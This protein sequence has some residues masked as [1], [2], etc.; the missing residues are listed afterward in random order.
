MEYGPGRS[1]AVLFR[2]VL[3]PAH[4]TWPIWNSLSAD[5]CVHETKKMLYIFATIM[6][7]IHTYMFRM[8]LCIYVTTLRLA[9]EIYL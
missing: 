6:K 5:T 1:W 9:I 2:T 7:R 3:G 8:G 4:W